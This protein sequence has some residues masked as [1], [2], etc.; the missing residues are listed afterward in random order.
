[1]KPD[2]S[3]NQGPKVVLVIALALMA[4]VTISQ[5]AAAADCAWYDVICLL[6][7]VPEPLPIR[8]PQ[9]VVT[10]PSYVPIRAPQP[11]VSQPSYVP[12][13]APQPVVSQPPYVP[14]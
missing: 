1:M 8:G 4:V 10:Q 9:P 11:V 2:T 12:T 6:N 14:T 3:K 7:L 5:P 13:R